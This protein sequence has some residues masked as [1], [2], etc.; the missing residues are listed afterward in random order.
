MTIREKIINTLE[1]LGYPVDLQGTYEENDIP[2]SLITYFIAGTQDLEHYN[3]RPAK[4]GYTINVNF[5]SRKMS[6]IDTAPELISE[7]LLG[8]GFTREGPGQD[9]GLDKDTRHYGWL[10]DFYYVERK[11]V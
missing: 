2:D 9:A 1:P 11:D 10:M 4:T 5:Y 6:L 3:N 7:A 8:A